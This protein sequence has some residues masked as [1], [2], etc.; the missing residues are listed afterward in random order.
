MQQQT[1]PY[2]Q[3]SNMSPEIILFKRDLNH[4][5]GRRKGRTKIKM[6]LIMK[7][8]TTI[9][10]KTIKSKIMLVRI[11]K[12]KEKRSIHENFVESRIS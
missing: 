10:I 3:N 1:N 12:R 11:R 7:L 2:Y 6:E 8:T 9:T 5:K 4:L